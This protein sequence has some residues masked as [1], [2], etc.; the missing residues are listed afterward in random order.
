MQIQLLG[1][2]VLIAVSLFLR[3][4]FGNPKQLALADLAIPSGEFINL[5]L[6]FGMLLFFLGHYVAARGSKGANPGS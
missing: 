1:Y 2:S 6:A 5:S 4:H 3:M